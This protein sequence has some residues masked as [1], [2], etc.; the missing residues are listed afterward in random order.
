MIHPYLEVWSLEQNNYESGFRNL[1]EFP[2]HFQ[3]V[4]GL[5]LLY[6]AG[7]GL[8][9]QVLGEPAA[10]AEMIAHEEKANPP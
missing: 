7:C 9:P 4:I 8:M 6:F 10:S 5:P 3:F 1:K 2:A